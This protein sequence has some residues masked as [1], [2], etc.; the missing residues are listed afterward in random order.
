MEIDC[1]LGEVGT[2]DAQTIDLLARLQLAARRC[3]C[4]LRFVGVSADL[5]DLVSFCGLPLELERQAEKR[6]K[7]L[8]VEEKGELADPPVA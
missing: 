4:S 5:R 1:D 7:P 6:E 8:G 2:A 3:G